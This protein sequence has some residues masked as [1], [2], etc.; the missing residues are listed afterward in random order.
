M[1]NKTAKRIH[2]VWNILFK[3]LPT[4][5]CVPIKCY[6]TVYN[7]LRT[8]ARDI[9]YPYKKTLNWYVDNWERQKT[10]NTNYITSKYYNHFLSKKHKKEAFGITAIA[11]YPIKMACDNLANHPEK[12]IAYLL[13]H[14]FAHH[15]YDTK[16][17]RKCDMFAIRWARKLIK[18]GLF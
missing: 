18:E 15:L 9:N 14:E 16:N 11:R 4:E 12:K 6:S 3:R 1:K 10:N 8:E 13:L 2:K 7:M 17:E 5:Y